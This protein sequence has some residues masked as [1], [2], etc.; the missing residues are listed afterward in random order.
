MNWI[1]SSKTSS[2]ATG[3]KLLIDKLQIEGS[4]LVPKLDDEGQC[5]A[6]WKHSQSAMDLGNCV[7]PRVICHCGEG[8]NIGDHAMSIFLSVTPVCL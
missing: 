7:V 4:C 3:E 8:V 6:A 5:A 1:T 2:S